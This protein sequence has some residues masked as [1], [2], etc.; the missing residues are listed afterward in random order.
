MMKYLALSISL[1]LPHTTAAA[2][3]PLSDAEIK[4]YCEGWKD[5]AQIVMS[6]RQEG[7]SREEAGYVFSSK[8]KPLYSDLANEAFEE[9][10][11]LDEYQREAAIK[12]FA[13]QQEIS[14]LSAMRKIWK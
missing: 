9:P 8:L 14:C 11:I 3:E 1:L 5:A 13:A 12:T 10:V 2:V 4:Q 6:R 7:V